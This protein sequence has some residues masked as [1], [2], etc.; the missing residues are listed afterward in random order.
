[1]VTLLLIFVLIIS[2][3]ATLI[4][5]KIALRRNLLDIPNYRSSHTQPT[6]RGGGIAILIAWYFG[7]FWL[8]YFKLIETNLF[9]ALISGFILALVSLMDDIFTIKPWIRILFQLLS[10]LSGIYFIGG[11]KILFL[12]D[13]KFIVPFALNLIFVIGAI[14]YINLY[15]FLDGIDG[16]ASTEAISIA[17]GMYMI[18]GNPVLLLLIFSVLGFLIWNWPRAM[19][20]M[21]DIGSTQLGYIFVILGIYFNNNVELNVIGLLILTSLFWFDATL[22]LYR[23]WKNNEKLSQAHKKHAYQRIVQF[24]FSHQKTIIISVFVNLIFIGL[25]YLSENDKV[26]YLITLPTCLIINA[27]ITK[28]INYRFPFATSGLSSSK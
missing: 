17:A 15:N 22:T 19:I 6:P 26:S 7:L 27:I 11:M 18:T 13:F 23:R 3:T 4:V 16:Y 24:G 12:N 8:Q 28:M 21:G 1:M 9:L 5:R 2:F 20:F 25:L 10:V 14:W